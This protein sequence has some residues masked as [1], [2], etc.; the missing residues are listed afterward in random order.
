MKKD[1]TAN[2]KTVLDVS[3][4]KS[5]DAMRYNELCERIG[6]TPIDKGKGRINQIKDIRR[7]LDM[8]FN[9]K[10]NLWEINEVYPYPVPKHTTEK[11]KYI[12]YIECLFLDKLLSLN[13]D[14]CVATKN[15]LYG[16]LYMVNEEYVKM[17]AKKND[18]DRDKARQRAA[19]GAPC[20]MD[21]HETQI[22]SEDDL[23]LCK[24]RE[25]LSRVLDRALK[26]MKDRCVIT[27]RDE[28][29]I[30]VK[31]YEDDENSS[32]EDCVGETFVDEDKRSYRISMRIATI[33]EE[34]LA[35]DAKEKVLRSMGLTKESQAAMYNR[36]GELYYRANKILYDKYGWD[37]TF[38]QYRIAFTPATVRYVLN[39]LYHKLDSDVDKQII[40][41]G[42]ALNRMIVSEMSRPKFFFYT[43]CKAEE[44]LNS[45]SIAKLI[46]MVHDKVE[47]DEVSP[48]SIGKVQTLKTNIIQDILKEAN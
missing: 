31:E 43:G 21:A 46:A 25:M 15:Q 36:T 33:D 32:Y 4:I 28:T 19:F 24:T 17:A 5:G 9:F 47:I 2:Q 1:N 14:C 18:G 48:N 30:V 10:T 6:I 13:S 38:K 11:S 12:E 37:S 3:K 35:T 22:R 34:A 41:N 27:Y 29:V 16:W 26:S 44:L 8:D 45:Q 40:E 23:F 42:K 7:Y 39:G 20:K